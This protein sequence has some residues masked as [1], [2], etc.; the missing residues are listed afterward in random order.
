M[1]GEHREEAIDQEK[2]PL[3]ETI[4]K[5]ASMAGSAPGTAFSTYSISSAHSLQADLASLS[6]EITAFK[7]HGDPPFVDIQSFAERI[8][9]ANL[10][11]ET[12]IA[13]LDKEKKLLTKQIDTIWGAFDTL[14]KPLWR[15]DDALV[16]IYDALADIRIRLEDLYQEKLDAMAS[17]KIV[18]TSEGDA[19]QDARLADLQRRM[20]ELEETFCVN[21][22]FVAPSWSGEGI[23]SGQAVVANLLAKNYRLIRMI[24]EAEPAVDKSLLPIQLRLQH[25]IGSLQ[26]FKLALLSNDPSVE[27]MQLTVLQSQ[28]DAIAN[29]QHNGT[30]YAPKEPANNNDLESLEAAFASLSTDVVPKGQA[31]LHNL[32]EDAY[33]LVHECLVEIERGEG[34]EEAFLVE[35]KQR[36]QQVLEVL[37]ELNEAADLTV[38]ESLADQARSRRQDLLTSPTGLQALSETLGQG[39]QYVKNAAG[40]VGSGATSTLTSLVRSGYAAV[41]K[42]LGSDA[43]D[44]TL[45]PTLRRLEGLK[46]AL[47]Q[48]RLRKDKAGLDRIRMGLPP[49]EMTEDMKRDGYEMRTHLVVLEEMDMERDEQGR[50]VN[51]EGGAPPEGQ[52]R[53][54][55][56][57]DE[58]FVLAYELI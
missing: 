6:H 53:L 10:S 23:P 27:P 14:I 16:P 57:L 18:S 1:F 42:A 30:F 56:L 40:A 26:H 36:V 46:Q 35:L 55:A 39:F 33:D 22:K 7:R 41:G 34:E 38:E 24:H 49:A 4:S 32:L 47:M 29:L 52:A 31:V 45:L 17:A 50:F 8:W 37:A 19:L 9:R 5:P 25:I 28:L 20:H 3:K 54:R 12:A 2:L 51:A 58:C 48:L 43:V 44:P 21:G 13:K 11:Y 15:V